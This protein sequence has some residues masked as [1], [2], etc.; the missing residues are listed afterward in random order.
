[1][2]YLD[3]QHDLYA[4]LTLVVKATHWQMQHKNLPS[5]VQNFDLNHERM[6]P[7]SKVTSRIL[8][9]CL[10]SRHSPANG[11]I[12]LCWLRTT[13]SAAP[14]FCTGLVRGRV[15]VCVLRDYISSTY[16]EMREILLPRLGRSLYWIHRLREESRIDGYAKDGGTRSGLTLM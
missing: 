2:K 14:P 13:Y 12:G 6:C 9:L 5:Q 4:F 8:K 15:L 7:Y 1:M 10:R 11:F 3:N 16:G